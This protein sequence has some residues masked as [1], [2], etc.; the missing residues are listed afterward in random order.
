V[1]RNALEIAEQKGRF[2][3][4]ALVDALTRMAREQE[5]ATGPTP[6][7]RLRPLVAVMVG[8]SPSFVPDEVAFDKG[9]DCA[10]R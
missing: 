3:I 9:T 10:A 5:N 8:S 6:T 1:A 4:F 7:K 2:T